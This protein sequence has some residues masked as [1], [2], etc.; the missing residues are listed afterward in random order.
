MYYWCVFLFFSK[1]KQKKKKKSEIVNHMKTKIRKVFF[2]NRSYIIKKP[3]MSSNDDNKNDASVAKR[4]VLFFGGLTARMGYKQ[5]LS[6]ATFADFCFYFFTIS[7][8]FIGWYF[9]RF[10]YTM[11]GLALCGIVCMIVMVPNWSSAVKSFQAGRIVSGA[12]EL[13]FLDNKKVRRYY[14]NLRKDELK[15]EPKRKPPLRYKE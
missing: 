13:N 6:I 4:I 8:Y 7:S 3:N 14:D 5:Q 11:Y 2:Q 15:V 9:Q 1:N 12:D 10:S